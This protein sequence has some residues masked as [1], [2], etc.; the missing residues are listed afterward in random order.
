MHFSTLYLMRNEELDNIGLGEIERDFSE[1]FCYCCGETHP[2][3]RYWCDWFQIGGRWA[4]PIVAKKGLTGERSWCNSGDKRISK[5][6]FAVAEIKDITEPLQAENIY[7]IA[8]KS[9]VYSEDEYPDEYHDLLDKINNKKI[10][11]VVA[12]IDCHD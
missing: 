6:N 7:A 2:R 8:T 3:Y 12:F 1:R 5:N 11:G 4:E 10:K 9:R